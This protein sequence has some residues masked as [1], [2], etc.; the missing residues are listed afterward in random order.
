MIIKVCGVWDA[1]NIRQVAAA[2]V[3]MLGFVFDKDDPH[4][5]KSELSYAGIIPDRADTDVRDGV[6][7]GRVA[8]AG[9][10]ADEMPQTVITQVYNYRLDYVQFGGGESKI[11]IDNL[12]RTL[13]PDIVAQVKIIKAFTVENAADVARA[14][15]FEGAA[16]M[17]LFTAAKGTAWR[18]IAAEY[19]GSTPFLLGGSICPDSAEGL[20]DG[21]DNPHFAGINISGEFDLPDGTVDTERLQRFV[22]EVRSKR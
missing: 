20:L 10:F 15:Y 4:Y 2:D 16:D 3:D 22:K 18:D 7:K 8:T 11:Y 1:E 13:V 6:E 9:V 21:I 17:F 14:A 12:R 5:V 19:K